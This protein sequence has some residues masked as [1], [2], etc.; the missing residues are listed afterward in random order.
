MFEGRCLFTSRALFFMCLQAK[1]NCKKKE[2]ALTRPII[3]K[4]VEEMEDHHDQSVERSECNV[5]L[6]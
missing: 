6:G 5:H 1:E 4:A 3:F 2:K